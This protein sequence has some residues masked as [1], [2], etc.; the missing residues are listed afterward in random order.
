MEPPL[1]VDLAGP[2]GLNPKDENKFGLMGVQ[3]HEHFT[4]A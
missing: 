4:A 1:D 2:N 3:A